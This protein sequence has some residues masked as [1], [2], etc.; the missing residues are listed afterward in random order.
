MK[1]KKAKYFFVYDHFTAP[2][3]SKYSHP[4]IRVFRI[5]TQCPTWTVGLFALQGQ[6]H[7]PDRKTLRQSYALNLDMTIDSHDSS[8]AFKVLKRLG[9][10]TKD[11][12]RN[13]VETLEALRKI[14]IPRYVQAVV[15]TSEDGWNRTEFVPRKYKAQAAEYWQALKDSMKS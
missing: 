3:G 2:S 12:P 10:G 4:T 7:T 6:C 8:E 11:Y 13:I 15:S 1:L 5:D 14:K 9:I